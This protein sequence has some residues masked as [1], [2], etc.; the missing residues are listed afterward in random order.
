MKGEVTQHSAEYLLLDAMLI[1]RGIFHV[2]PQITTVEWKVSTPRGAVSPGKPP[3]ETFPAHT[4][5]EYMTDLV[6][7]QCRRSARSSSI[8]PE[9]AALVITDLSE[10]K[11]RLPLLLLTPTIIADICADILPGDSKSSSLDWRGWNRLDVFPFC[12]PMDSECFAH[13][14]R[15][16]FV[17]IHT[18][19]NDRCISQSF[20]HMPIG[21]RL[22]E[23]ILHSTLMH[24]QL[25]YYELNVCSG[26]QSVT[27]RLIDEYKFLLVMRAIGRCRSG[28]SSNAESVCDLIIDSSST[29][30]VN[31]RISAGEDDRGSAIIS[32]ASLPSPG[33]SSPHPELSCVITDSAVIRTSSSFLFPHTYLLNIYLRGIT[34][35]LFRP[36][37]CF[38]VSVTAEDGQCSCREI[39]YP[40]E[41]SEPI[42]ICL[43]AADIVDSRHLRIGLHE[44]SPRSSGVVCIA[45][46]LVQTDVLI[47][48]S[49]MEIGQSTESSCD[50]GIIRGLPGTRGNGKR[51]NIHVP[52]VC[53]LE[54]KYPRHA[55]M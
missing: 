8:A 48:N 26:G 14:T 21:R 7:E 52:T 51:V 6:T 39:V 29:V 43:T 27:F 30:P 11:H 25:S 13:V 5:V 35:P 33:F 24:A 42:R 10:N 28:F 47:S 20:P 22:H 23:V 18:H 40:N 12:T 45:E 41:S 36:S 2:K 16:G 4:V 44:L 34:H 15:W 32:W 54:L 9:L 17:A 1:E 31:L 3:V 46:C 49:L 55:I 38:V 50:D 53:S 37:S 19:L